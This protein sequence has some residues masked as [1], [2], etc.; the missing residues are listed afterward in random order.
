MLNVLGFMGRD[1]ASARQPPAHIPVHYKRRGILKFPGQPQRLE[2]WPFGHE[3]CPMHFAPLHPRM[4]ARQGLD[5]INL[6][7]DVCSLLRDLGGT[8][9]IAYA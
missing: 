6:S 4:P 2:V 1:A 3:A 7:A 8:F 5:E 9:V